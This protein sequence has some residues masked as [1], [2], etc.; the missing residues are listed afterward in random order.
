VRSIGRITDRMLEVFAPRLTASAAC[1][2][3]S[4]TKFV[5]CWQ[6]FAH[7]QQCY[8]PFYCAVTCGPVYASGSC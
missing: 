5:G 8:V 6:G 7:Y 4:Y 1:T 2:P 3:H